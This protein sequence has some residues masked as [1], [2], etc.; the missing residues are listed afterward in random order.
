MDPDPDPEGPK[1]YG[2]VGSGSAT[3]ASTII[4]GGAVGPMTERP[5]FFHLNYLFRGGG[6]CALD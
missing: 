2:S 1:T 4:K 3:L 6:V 5:A